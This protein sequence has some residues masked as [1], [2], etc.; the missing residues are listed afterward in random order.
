MTLS[1]RTHPRGLTGWPWADRG[2]TTQETLL[3]RSA[4]TGQGLADSV[5]YQAMDWAPCLCSMGCPRL[6]PRTVAGPSQRK[7]CGRQKAARRRL[8][9]KPVSP[10]YFFAASAALLAASLAAS[11]AFLA[12]SAAASTA[13][14]AAAEAPAAA[15]ST[16]AE[17]APT[18]AEAASVAAVAAP[19]AAEAAASAA[20]AT[21]AEAAPAAAEAASSGFLPQAA[22]ATAAT[23]VAIRSDLFIVILNK[24]KRGSNRGSNIYRNGNPSDRSPTESGTKSSNLRI[25]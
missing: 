12:A 5:G 21:T 10:I 22:R 9:L 14:P 3:R 15:A 6:A 25:A 8:F 7:H 11:P 1:S 24:V 2:S 19:E 18:A 16:A 13:A 17:A 4:R 23:R 20:G